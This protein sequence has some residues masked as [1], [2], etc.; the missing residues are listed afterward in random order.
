MQ[1]PDGSKKNGSLW[2]LFSRALAV[3]CRVIDVH[4][5]SPAITR[6]FGEGFEPHPPPSTGMSLVTETPL[7]P[8]E[9][10]VL[11]SIPSALLSALRVPNHRW[12]KTVRRVCAVVTGMGN[13][14]TGAE[15]RGDA[16]WGNLLL[17]GRVWRGGAN[18]RSIGQHNIRLA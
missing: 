2:H 18:P 9:M 4:A 12:V 11:N 13:L 6:S 10:E 1:M 5:A 16:E 7:V 14:Y 17:A 8:A 15:R 3:V